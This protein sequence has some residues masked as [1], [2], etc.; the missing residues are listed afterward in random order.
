MDT[1]CVRRPLRRPR[2]AGELRGGPGCVEQANEVGRLRPPPLPGRDDGVGPRDLA[3]GPLRR[4]RAEERT[5]AAAAT[6][7]SEPSGA[8][9]ME[10]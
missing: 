8:T 5:K 10:R 1:A 9:R 7:R 4:S 6:V 2:V 3:R